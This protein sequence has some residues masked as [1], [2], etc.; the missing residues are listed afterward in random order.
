[1]RTIHP[2]GLDAIGLA[3]RP[4]GAAITSP[5]TLTDVAA[6]AGVSI[7]TASRALAGKPRVSQ[8]MIVR[9]REI[10]EEMGYRVNP[11][12]RALRDGSS[13]LVGMVVPVIGIPFYARLVDAVEEELNRAGYELLLA[14]SHG[15]VEEETR[16]L[17]VLRDRRVDGV[18][19]IPSDRRKTATSMRSLGGDIAVVQVDRATDKPLADFVGVDNLVGLGLVVE[20]LAERGVS[21]IAYAGT[22]DASSNGVERWAAVQQLAADHEMT[23]TSSF[24]SEFS[25]AAGAAAADAILAAGPLA[26]AVVASSDQI[27]VGLISRLREKGFDVPRDTL[28]TGFDGGELADVYWPTL[29][30]VVQP[31]AAIAADAVTF[32]LARMAKHD[33]AVR[34]NTLAPL[35]QVGASTGG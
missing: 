11:M 22:D 4:N 2:Q 13:R 7:A 23:I 29:T 33:G 14:D 27:A 3:R 18:I 35:L 21:T 1:M 20:H 6:R 28:V 30:T 16:R 9:V 15:F 25:I 26:D 19:L 5:V 32:L 12:A 24:R 8:E 17:Q 34:R 31:V 10:A